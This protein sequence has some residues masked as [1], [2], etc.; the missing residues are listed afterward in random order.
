[1]APNHESRP[2]IKALGYFK[3]K[4]YLRRQLRFRLP[5]FSTR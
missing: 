4:K 1:L 2:V 3:M 5:K